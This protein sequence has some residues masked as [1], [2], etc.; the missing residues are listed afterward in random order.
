MSLL[1]IDLVKQ[2]L[3]VDF[4]DDDTIIAA[5]QA[6]A[7]TIV[8]EYIDR[9]LVS[10]GETPATTDGIA[11][12]PAITV[13]ILLLTAAMYENSEADEAAQRDAVLPQGVRT[14]LAPYRVWRVLDH[15][16]S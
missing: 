2:H 10:S 15:F 6:A 7:E 16:G 8:A 4:D 3:R 14:L 1:D 12:T 9:E 11:V 5:Y 13:A